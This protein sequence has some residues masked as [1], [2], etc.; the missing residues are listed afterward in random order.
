MGTPRQERLNFLRGLEKRHPVTRAFHASPLP[1]TKRLNLD[2]SGLS[3][4][5]RDD[6]WNLIEKTLD[7]ADVSQRLYTSLKGAVRFGE[8]KVID[9]EDG[10]LFKFRPKRGE[11]TNL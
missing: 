1:P 5:S 4:L 2:L 10:L 11:R 9:T 8:L 7:R 6:Q 3:P